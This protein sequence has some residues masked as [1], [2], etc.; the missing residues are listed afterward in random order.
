MAEKLLQH[1]HCRSCNKAILPDLDFC[2]DDCMS[3]HKERMRKKRNQLLLL[4][5]FAVGM[6]LLTLIPA[7]FSS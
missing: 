3:Q 2:N 1:R 5:A 7:L 6:M 4:F